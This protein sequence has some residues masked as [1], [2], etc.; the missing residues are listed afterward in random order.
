MEVLKFPG[1]LVDLITGVDFLALE[2]WKHPGNLV[3][4]ITRV[5]FLALEAWKH[6]EAARAFDRP[7]YSGWL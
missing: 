7:T 5:D 4:L 1:N 2:A 6:P 3:D